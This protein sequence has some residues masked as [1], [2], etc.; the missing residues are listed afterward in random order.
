MA[1][2][3]KKGTIMDR[4]MVEEIF[5][6]LKQPAGME[7]VIFSSRIYNCLYRKIHGLLVSGVKAKNKGGKQ[8]KLFVNKLSSSPP[9]KIRI[10]L[11]ETDK[12]CL[13]YANKRLYEQN[14][15][16]EQKLETAVIK[17]QKLENDL[18]K[19]KSS[20]N[21]WKSRFRGI[22]ERTMKQQRI[23]V[24]L[25]RKDKSFES[26]SQRSK[27]RLKK[28][29]KTTCQLALDFMGLYDLVPYKVT[30]YNPAGESFDS[31][32]LIEKEEFNESFLGPSDS[33]PEQDQQLDNVDLLLYI[34]DKFHVSDRAW[35]EIS[36]ISKELPTKCTLKQRIKALNNQWTIKL[37]PGETDGVQISFKD[38]LLEQVERLFIQ[39]EI[40]PCDVLK[41]KLSGDGTR[42]GKR[43]QLLNVTYSIINEGKKASTEKG[44]YML[45]IVKA[46]DDYEGIR[47]SLNDLREEMA[48]LAFITCQDVSFKIE[49][50]LGGDWKFLATVCGI[51]PANQNI[52]CIWCL[53]PKNLRHDVEKNW[54]LNDDDP[55]N[56][57]RTIQS[58]TQD[59][60]SRKNNCQRKP[61][62]E[63]I[64]MDHVVIDSLHLFLRITDI[65][66]E[67]LILSLKTADAIEKR[68]YF[69]GGIDIKK[70]KHLEKYTSFLKGLNIQFCLSVNRDTN[71]LQY[72]DLTGPE[73]LL[74]FQ[75]IKIKDLLPQ[76]KDAEQLQSVY[77]TFLNLYLELGN[78]FLADQVERYE[79]KI[80]KWTQDFLQLF[81]TRDVTPYMHAFWCHVP[82]FLHLYGNISNFNQQGLEKCNDIISKDYFRS[83]NHQNVDALRQLMLK[84][85]RLQ[86]LEAK[87]AQRVKGSYL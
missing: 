16:L 1:K 83:T 40:A 75:N 32:T 35:H 68:S 69:H 42:V 27:F 77:D 72:R 8:Y 34:K 57:S 23:A 18:L 41:I 55:D 64:A 25:K 17:E 22:V 80:K 53:C 48:S 87:G 56:L 37:T 61:L 52:A 59:S 70:Y 28:Q 46:K 58:I 66:I 54:P 10:L 11:S 81:Q 15:R 36:Q 63:F 85:Q 19:A 78:T 60:K 33:T 24:K 20:A 29:L 51:G 45:A 30:F 13:T 6:E 21:Y 12:L 49:Y 71:K 9:Y 79:Q 2:K 62:F 47:D 4:P 67:N 7:D 14:I 65:L 38:S 76:Y 50:F 86:H 73:K 3:K 5:N 26:Y 74:L 31:I 44:N 84:K 82:Q 43:L 39:E